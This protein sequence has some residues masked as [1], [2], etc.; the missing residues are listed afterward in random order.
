MYVRPN[1]KSDYEKGNLW[2]NCDRYLDDQGY[3]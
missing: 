3:P 2:V 1:L